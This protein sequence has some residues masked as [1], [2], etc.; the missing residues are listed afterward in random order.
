MAGQLLYP[1]THSRSRPFRARVVQTFKVTQIRM[2]QRIA[3]VFTAAAAVLLISAAPANANSINFSGTWANGYVA[4]PFSVSSPAT[5]NFTWNG[6]YLDAT[7]ALFDAG[8][9]HLITN[10][11]QT[12]SL[13]P[14]LT[15]NLAA[16]S[17]TLVTSY[18]CIGVGF[19]SGGGATPVGTDGFNTASF[20]VGGTSTLAG[21]LAAITAGINVFEP[22][23][24]EEPYSFTISTEANVLSTTAPTQPVPEPGTWLLLGSG[25]AAL[26]ARARRRR[27]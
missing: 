22:P 4:T 23:T 6:G 10:D 14:I 13:D 25:L 5:V 2:M 1:R 20:L 19:V 7:F 9:N 8:G 11:D 3:H 27:G 15:Q 18:C 26:V 16:G 17:Y 21:T 24:G 12:S